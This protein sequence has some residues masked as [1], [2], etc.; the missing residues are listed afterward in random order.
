VPLFADTNRERQAEAGRPPVVATRVHAVSVLDDAWWEG[1]VKA[2]YKYGGRGQ[3]DLFHIRFKP[4]GMQDKEDEEVLE[5]SALRCLPHDVNCCAELKRGQ[6]VLALTRQQIWMDAIIVRFS[7]GHDGQPCQSQH[8]RSS[9][10]L[11][12]ALVRLTSAATAIR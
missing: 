1:T 9:Q 8:T 5:L 3:E 12:W 2:I 10:C 4:S 11:C 6:P 7:T